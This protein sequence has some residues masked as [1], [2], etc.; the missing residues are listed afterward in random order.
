MS[1]SA[2][3]WFNS[4][5]VALSETSQFVVHHNTQVA[6][7]VAPVFHAHVGEVQVPFIDTRL[8]HTLDA[9]RYSTFSQQALLFII[10][11]PIALVVRADGT[12]AVQ[13]APLSRSLM[14]CA[15]PSARTR[16]Q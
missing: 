10:Y 2:S 12:E 8:I 3:D 11:L 6:A 4:L 9:Q 13:V 14:L 5:I 1:T 15:L 7:A 16:G